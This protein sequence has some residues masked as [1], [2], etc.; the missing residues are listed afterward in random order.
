[1]NTI[2]LRYRQV[3][4]VVFLSFFLISTLPPTAHGSKKVFQNSLGMEFISVPEG[5]FIM[6][7][8]A[9]ESH[10]QKDEIQHRVTISKPFYLQLSEV[11][12][13]QWRAL[14]GKKLF[15][16]RK[17]PANLPVVKVSWFNVRRFIKKLN[18]RGEGYYRLPTEAEWEYAARAGSP[19][20]YSWG[21][22]ID[23]KKAMYGNN[24]KKANECLK[25]VQS[26]GF[27][28]DRPV[29][30]KSYPPN[31][32]GLYDMHGNVWEWCR[33][34]YGRYATTDVA[35]PSGPP[36]GSARVRRGGSWFQHGHACRSATRTHANPASK[37]Q[38][39]GFRLIWS[40][41][42]DRYFMKRKAKE[43]GLIGEQDGP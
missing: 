26:R 7:S 38:T 33:D 40:K 9:E 29:P 3:F 31:A 34:W 23:C 17:G 27:D 19:T 14:M 35:D 32:W 6:G 2:R 24:R 5:T 36:S 43:T 22:T 28:P 39:T 4:M 8:P 18:K 13:K 16:R 21:D 20:A 10:R 41:T 1:M 42:P 15:G 30:V 25:Y 11:T 37:F 12:L